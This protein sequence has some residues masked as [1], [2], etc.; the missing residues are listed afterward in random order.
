L[1]G[2]AFIEPPGWYE[3]A[4]RHGERPIRRLPWNGLR[5]ARSIPDPLTKTWSENMPAK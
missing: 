5:L 3:P 4:A 1:R 2:G